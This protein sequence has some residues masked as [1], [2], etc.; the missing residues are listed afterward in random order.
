MN[1]LTFRYSIRSQLPGRRESAAELGEKFIDTLDALTRIDPSVF[2]NWQVMDLPA[3]ASVPLA[4]ARL[5]IGTIIENNIIRDD[6]GER[7]PHYGYGIVAFTGDVVKSRH[8][9]LRIK[10]GGTS[11]G[12]ICWRPDTGKFLLIRR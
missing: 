12:D 8:V 9:N 11:N 4:T 2:T 3:K 10:A 7:D 1:D 6:L 5:R